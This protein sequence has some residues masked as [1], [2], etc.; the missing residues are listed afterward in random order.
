MNAHVLLLITY[1]VSVLRGGWGIVVRNSQFD[2]LRVKQT[3][4]NNNINI[5]K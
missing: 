1:A 2:Q 3:K 5:N 4:N